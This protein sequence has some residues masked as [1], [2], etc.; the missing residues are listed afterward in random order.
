MILFITAAVLLTL[1][2]IALLFYPTELSWV[3]TKGTRW[4]YDKSAA[5]YATKWERHNYSSYDALISKAAASLKASSTDLAVLDLCCGTGRA[6]LVASRALGSRANYT[7]IDFSAAMLEQLK[8]EIASSEFAQTLNIN[9][10]Q[11]DVQQW[12]Q[13]SSACF[14]L[15]LF[16]EAGEFLPE[17]T[18]V[19]EHLGRACNRGGYLVMTKPTAF[20]C[21]FFP[22][23][24]QTRRQL[25][26]QLHW[27]GFTEIT[28]TEWRSRY[29]LVTARKI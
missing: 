24:S 3:S 22:A 8:Q 25:S 13:H 14:D 29:E 28:F 21:T 15:I 26:A 4:L 2:G 16:M 5:S 17:F 18:D 6:T 12:V 7:A 23:R 9:V 11:E 20:W 1:A 19:I 27:A 10:M